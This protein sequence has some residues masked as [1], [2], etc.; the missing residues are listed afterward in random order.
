L[1]LNETFWNSDYWAMDSRPHMVIEAIAHTLNDVYQQSGGSGTLSVQL[2][3]DGHEM[4]VLGQ[5]DV[6]DPFTPDATMVATP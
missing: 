6:A 4:S 2:L 3:R 5:D 1:S